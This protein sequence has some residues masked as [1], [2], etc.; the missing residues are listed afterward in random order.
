MHENNPI[1]SQLL[2]ENDLWIHPEPA[3]ALGIKDGAMVEVSS[4]G[5]SGQIR[6][7]VT[8]RIHPESVY[9]LHGFGTQV[10][11][12]KRAVGKGLADQIFMQGKLTDWDKAGGGVNVCQSF[13]TIKPA[14]NKELK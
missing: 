11:L 12:Q 9:M 13:V 10:P 1:L 14:A 2:D 7:K 5:V 4:N 8:N 6:A 3:A